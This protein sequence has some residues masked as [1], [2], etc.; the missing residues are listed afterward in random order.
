MSFAKN[1]LP[2]RIED[3]MRNSYLD[4]SMSVIIGRALPDVRDGLKPVHRRILYAMHKEGLFANKKYSKCAG[5]V[6][7]VLKKY[8]PHGDSAVYDALVRMAQP[9]NLR[10]LLVDGQGNFGSVDGDP[11][12]AYRYTECKM[13]KLAQE[14]MVDIDR[15]TVSFSPNFDGTA[16]EPDVMPAR[17][18]NLLV[19]GADGIAVGMATKIPPHNLTEIISGCVALIDNPDIELGELME[20]IPGP[21]FPT[22]ATIFGRLGIYDAYKTGR[23]RVVVRG[24]SRVE[25]LP[26][27]RQTIIIDELPY[28]VNKARLI[29]QIADLVRDKRI[30]GIHT[31]RDES[32]REGMRIVIE[33]KMDVHEEV[34]I[35]L[36]YKH[37]PLQ[38]TFGVIMLA[39]VNQ[40][41]RVLSLREMLSHY[42][43][44]RREVILRRT[45]HDL[46]KAR[47]R[48][49]ILEG[50]RIALDQLDEV[51]ATIRSSKTVGE[52]RQRLIE[53][54]AFTTI[55]AQAI[56]ELRLQRLT[57]MERNRIDEE[58][59]A[60]LA[61][62]AEMESVL[63]SEVLL[64]AEVRKELIEIRDEYGDERRTKIIEATG[65]LSM[66]DLVAAEEQVVTLSHLGYIKR[67]S[68]DEWR[69]Q[70]RGGVGKRGMTTRESDFVTTLFI[71]N[72]H[73]I[74]LVFTSQ[75]RVYPLNVYEVPEAGRNARGRPII[76]LVPVDQE[77][78]IA[79]VQSVMSND[80]KIDDDDGSELLFVSAQGL[81]KRTPLRQYKN[82]RQG[83]IIACGVGE[84]DSLEIVRHI[85]EGAEAH[86]MLLSKSGKCIRFALSQAPVF[87]RTARGNRGI[88]LGG[89]DDTVVDALLVPAQ[90]VVSLEDDDD[91]EEVEIEMSEQ[92][93]AEAESTEAE[94][95]P[96]EPWDTTL[97]TVT[98]FGYG[99]RTP[100]DQYRPQNRY[101]KGIRAYNATNKTGDVVGALEV[102]QDNHLMLVTDTGRI[103]RIRAGS[104]RVI[105]RVSQGVRLMRLEEGERIVDIARLDD[106]E[107]EV[108]S[109]DEI[110]EADLGETGD[111]E[112]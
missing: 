18:P 52:A 13:T 111:G 22:G 58:Y 28:Q 64:L 91:S 51:I 33:L 63:G 85:E 70:R 93:E 98:E 19:N 105:G 23:G 26:N 57:G 68:P 79:A 110:D 31:L 49:H 89:P 36:L 108:P 95:E 32:D 43:A 96:L 6:G 67:C 50:Y 92:P 42:V 56:L 72:T 71:A 97:M 16:E 1:V 12:A 4:Y 94:A 3:E 53:N 77:E 29:E 5:V 20:H 37:T 100:F 39:I 69:Q 48:A 90:G 60:L 41:P 65:D 40:R 45:R 55:Q 54:F 76:N 112:E 99:K 14:L 103:I 104:A 107:E 81:V 44:H 35:N 17:F 88:Q 21:D 61:K 34:I 11:A 84:G 106:P 101:G 15:N 109:T 38:S 8:H 25:E 30:E 102:R 82:I 66:R 47:Q 2:I 10:Y 9:W 7:E 86:V 27:G 73:S 59:A 75:G 78:T 74:L 87:G 46:M 24:R 80:G 62:I 83:G